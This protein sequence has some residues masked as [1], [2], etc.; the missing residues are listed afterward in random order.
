MTGGSFELTATEYLVVCLTGD[1]LET[2][3]IAEVMGVRLDSVG[4]HVRNICT[5][6]GTKNRVKW[7]LRFG[8]WTE[9]SAR[10]KRCAACN[11]FSFASSVCVGRQ[12]HVYMCDCCHD[13][14]ET[15]REE[16]RQRERSECDAVVS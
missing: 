5:K 14:L 6:L 2:S 11:K 15:V 4:F 8:T 10:P 13:R 12:F 3:E 1:G 7:L 16:S 9:S